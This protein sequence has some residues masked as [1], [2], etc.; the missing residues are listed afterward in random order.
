MPSAKT[1]GALYALLGLIFGALF[2]LRSLL[3]TAF[4]GTQRSDVPGFAA[5]FGIG[6]IVLFPILNGVIGFLAGLIGA[7]LYNIVAG[8]VGGIEIEALQTQSQ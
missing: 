4:T 6:A 3:G 7:W 2:S 1:S 8:V 5:L